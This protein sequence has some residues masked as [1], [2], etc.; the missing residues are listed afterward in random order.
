MTLS[1]IARLP[2]HPVLWLVVAGCLVSVGAVVA[3][4]GPDAPPKDVEKFLGLWEGVDPLDAS[5]VLLSL[6]DV[7]DD[8]ILELTLEEAF[9]TA[10]FNLGSDYSKGRGVVTGTATVASKGVLDASTELICFSDANV[11]HSLGVASVQYTLRSHDRVLLIPEF[12]NAPAI[13]MHRI[14]R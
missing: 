14:S 5:P 3:G 4:P 11:P 2:W 8:G 10:C 9:W 12:G 7:D 6:S 1:R 13:V